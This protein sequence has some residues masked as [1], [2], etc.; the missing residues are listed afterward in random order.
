M[1]EQKDKHS[2]PPARAPKSQ[3]ATEQPL[4]GGRRNTPK[5]DSPHPKTK[6]KPQ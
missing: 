6:K 3:L 5:K 4:T 2:S 1:A